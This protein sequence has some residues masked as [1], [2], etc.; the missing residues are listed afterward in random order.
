[1]GTIPHGGTGSDG[2][3]QVNVPVGMRWA[4]PLVVDLDGGLVSGPVDP[5]DLS[6][7]RFNQPALDRIRLQRRFKGRVLLLSHLSYETALWVAQLVGLDNCVDCLSEEGTGA[8]ARGEAMARRSLHHFEANG[9]DFLGGRPSV[10]A[11]GPYARR[12]W[13]VGTDFD[14]KS[15]M[16][17]W[18]VTLSMLD[19]T[20][21]VAAKDLIA[22]GKASDWDQDDW[23]MQPDDLKRE[24][25]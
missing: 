25:G 13:L 3:H 11:V 23:A 1:M 15:Q 16:R 24:T 14:L 19:E 9:F 12:L 6:Q 22:D 17:T 5:F 2:T 4:A 10:A 8:K 18:G 21:T 7:V 20:A